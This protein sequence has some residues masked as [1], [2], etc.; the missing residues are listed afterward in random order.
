MQEKNVITKNE[1]EKKK[2][3]QKHEIDDLKKISIK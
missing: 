2:K 3:N 1:I